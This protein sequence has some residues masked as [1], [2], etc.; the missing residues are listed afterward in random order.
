[1][2]LKPKNL[3]IP[4]GNPFGEDA[5]TRSQSAHVLTQ[6]VSTIQEPFVLAIDSPWGTGKTTFI[7]MWMAS[8][9]E[10]SGFPC[11]CF[12]AWDS[13]FTGDPLVSFIGEMKTSLDLS[14]KNAGA[15]T[16]MEKY[17]SKGKK[18]LGILA[19]TSV[20]LGIKVLTQGILDLEKLKEFGIP[21]LAE[22]L[23]KERI[24]QYEMDKNTIADFKAHLKDV[25]DH[26]NKHESGETKPLTFFIDELDRCRPTYA[27][28]LLEKIKHLFNV[29]GIVFVLALDKV[30]IGHSIRSI[31]G[32]GMD[33]D[34]YLRRII[35]LEY[36]LPD[37]PRPDFCESLYNRFN[38]QELSKNRRN[39]ADSVKE[40]IEAFSILAEI[41]QVSL[42]TIEQ[43]FAQLNIVFRTASRDVN[44][45]PSLL[46]FLIALRAK[47]LPL[48]SS[49]TKET[50][51]MIEVCSFITGLAGGQKYWDSYYGIELEAFH[52]LSKGPRPSYSIGKEPHKHT[53]ENHGIDSPQGKRAADILE[54]IDELHR[55]HASGGLRSTIQRIELT[56][57]FTIS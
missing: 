25:I 54:Q 31:Y 49:L 34:G 3:T 6:L 1:M 48:Y 53:L 40:F 47:N 44:F 29:D 37:P 39:G 32:S 52:A 24:E 13:D 21:D 30:Q 50:P 38:L 22:S 27:I 7:K 23:A 14:L 42:R 45:P 51:D 12:N 9:K 33:V 55:A 16:A 11:I 18:L 19:R 35:D 28:D 4:P 17:V 41:F 46:A 20:P 15:S 2:Q 56:E 26:L 57:Q 43:C 5:L 10:K 8:L 36:R